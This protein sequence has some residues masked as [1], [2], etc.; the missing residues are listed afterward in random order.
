M[1][2]VEP[3]PAAT[4]PDDG[5]NATVFALGRA[6]ER[7]LRKL[8]TLDGQVGRLADQV[9][10]L[11]EQLTGDG[12]EAADGPEP[13]T[14]PGS[15]AWL[16]ADDPDQ[17]ATDLDDLARWVGRVYLWYP[18]AALSSCWL[19]HPEV[20]EELWWLRLAHA[21]A[22]DPENGSVL[23]MGD[24]HDRQ[25]PGVARR[26][27]A[28]LG[29]CDLTRHA[30]HNGR[31]V[32]ITPPGPPAMSG[33]TGVVAAVWAAGASLDVERATGPE[34]TIEQLAEADAYQRALYRSHR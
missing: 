31:S 18:D 12:T 9:V 6:V 11:G 3:P 16:L 27:R 32:E 19:W 7:A 15:R 23:R 24:W 2:A 8:G 34:P 21:D 10:A 5:L 33:H 30:A 4:P 22:Y 28:V 29:K 17:A 13:D 14:V 20:I 1:T 26:I 25:R